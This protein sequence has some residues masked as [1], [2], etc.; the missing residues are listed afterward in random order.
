MQILANLQGKQRFSYKK[1]DL[2]ASLIRPRMSL[3]PLTIYLSLIIVHSKASLLTVILGWVLIL[4]SYGIVVIHNDLSDIEVDK[5]NSR[6]DTPLA[7]NSLSKKDAYIA[8][9][10]AS[11]VG[12]LSALVIHPLAIAWLITYVGFGWL[13]SG[14]LSL[15]NRGFFALTILAVCY[16]VMPWILGLIISYAPLDPGS[17]V[18]ML[19]S[20]LYVFGIISL[21]DFKDVNGD[22][23]HRKMTILV[24]RGVTYTH[25]LIV[26]FTTTGYLTLI[27]FST[28]HYQWILSLVGVLLMTFNILILARQDIIS[29]SR[30]RARYGNISRLLFFCFAIAI[31]IFR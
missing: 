22:K 10:V 25:R 15:K 6:Q 9:L 21:K 26:A 12:I 30:L 27:I 3:L 5:E 1:A 19:A 11:V 4:T 31:Y 13:Y 8:L 23:K 18:V 20:F 29:T 24:K 16:G 2:F 14:G 28:L 17:L 7:T